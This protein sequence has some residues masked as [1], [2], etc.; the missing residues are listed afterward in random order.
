VPSPAWSR[1]AESRLILSEDSEQELIEA[2][3]GSSRWLVALDD[4]FDEDSPDRARGQDWTLVSMKS[5]GSTVFAD[6]PPP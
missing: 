3:S 4:V 2:A 6:A 1:S 5:D